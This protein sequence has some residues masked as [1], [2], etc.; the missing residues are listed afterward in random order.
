MWTNHFNNIILKKYHSLSLRSS[1]FVHKQYNFLLCVVREDAKEK[2]LP[3][4][5]NGSEHLQQFSVLFYSDILFREN[6]TGS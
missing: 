2:C 6:N 1:H 5:A 3:D 4:R